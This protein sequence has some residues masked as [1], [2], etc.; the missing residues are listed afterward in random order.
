VWWGG[1]GT[2]QLKGK[3]RKDKGSGS[4]LECDSSDED[5]ESLD[6]ADEYNIDLDIIIK[7][8]RFTNVKGTTGY[9]MGRYSNQ[10]TKVN[11]RFEVEPTLWDFPE[12]ALNYIYNNY[13]HDAVMVKHIE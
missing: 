7:Y 5:E 4:D 11:D 6:D 3:K 2:R 1:G 13:G 9:F 8:F 10:S 12:N